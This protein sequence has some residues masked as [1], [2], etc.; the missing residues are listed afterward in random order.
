[1]ARLAAALL[2]ASLILALSAVPAS[3]SGQTAGVQTHLLWPG[4]DGQEVRRQ[5]DLVRDSGAAIARVDVGWASLQQTSRSRYETWFLDR[6]DLVVEAADARGVDLLLTFMN[7]PCWASTAPETVKQ[8]CAGAWW[9]RGVTAY[10]PAD[11]DDYARAI[12]FLAA[13]YRGRVEAWEIWNEPNHSGFWRAGD[14]ASAYAALLKAAYP[15]VKA[16]DPAATVVG[17]SLSHSD[18]AFAERLYQLGVKGSFDAFAVHPYSDDVSPL[19]P[20]STID[21]RYSFVRGVP[22]IREVMLRHGDD[23]PIWLTESGWST[24]TIRTTDPWRNGV[25]EATQALFLRQQAEQVARW[26]WVQVSVW[27]NLL[28]MGAGREDLYSNCGLWRVDGTPKPAW[29][30]FRESAAMLA[31]TGAVTAPLPPPSTG[32]APAGV[33]VL[34]PPPAGASPA[35]SRPARR[36]RSKAARRRA[37]R[38]RARRQRARRA[39]IRRAQARRV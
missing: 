8:G 29:T 15:A 1:L 11:P 12:G 20:R 35:P 22:R 25:S 6:L 39:R 18:H 38:A 26:P 9:E 36:K 2:T 23:R 33:A 37:A 30:A 16:A 7:T 34:P 31:G 27:F 24:S 13:R 4:V 3:A 21:P 28:D 14:A 17:G 32:T 5:L 10:A 19:D